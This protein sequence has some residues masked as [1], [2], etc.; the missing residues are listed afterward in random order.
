MWLVFAVVWLALVGMRHR[1]WPKMTHFA[2]SDVYDRLPWQAKERLRSP[3][4]SDPPPPKGL[5]R[6]L[7]VQQQRGPS[8]D[9]GIHRIE[10]K[11]GVSEDDMRF[12]ARAYEAEMHALLNERRMGHVQSVLGWGFIPPAFLFAAGWTVAWIRRG[13]RQP[14]N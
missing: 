10:F 1:T 7:S 11:A 14:A 13:F 5:A 12:V 3:W 9:V 8:V 4:E 2:I 6:L